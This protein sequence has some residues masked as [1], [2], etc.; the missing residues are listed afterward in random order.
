MVEDDTDIRRGLADAL[1]FAGFEVLQA[2]DGGKGLAEALRADLD[3]L[4]LDLIL[5]GLSGYE[6]LKAVRSARPTLPVILLTA[7][8]EEDDRIRGLELG[9]DDYIT[10]PFSV[11]ELLARVE[12]VLRR[13]PERPSPIQSLNLPQGVLDL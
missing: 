8:G 12:A 9:A 11:R 10:K 3:L 2:G 13:S 5:P 7:R 6:L 4:V 1:R